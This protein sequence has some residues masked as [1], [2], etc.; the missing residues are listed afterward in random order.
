[1][2]SA[3]AA[4][5]KKDCFYKAKYQSM[6]P[7]R[8]KKRA[9]LAIG[10]KIL[11]AAYHILSNKEPFKELGGDFLEER[12]RKNRLNNL[13]KELNQLGYKVEKVA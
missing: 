10:H 1:M 6:V 9:L 12:R 8:G 13:T 3:W 7:R 4:T 5:R 11:C 2:E